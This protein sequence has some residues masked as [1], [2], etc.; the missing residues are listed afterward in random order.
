MAKVKKTS[1]AKATAAGLV[2]RAMR[3]FALF[4]KQKGLKCQT[5][6][7]AW[8]NLSGSERESFVEQSRM[9]FASQRA[10]GVQVG[11]VYKKDSRTNCDVG[12]DRIATAMEGQLSPCF[13]RL[14]SSELQSLQLPGN[15]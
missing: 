1:L 7:T 11:V 15:R 5:A 3:P 14:P 8:K 6:S 9:L 10:Q 12:T 4:C 13:A 2:P